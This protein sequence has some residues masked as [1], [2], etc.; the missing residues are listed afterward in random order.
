MSFFSYHLWDKWRGSGDN[1]LVQIKNKFMF[2]MLLSRTFTLTTLQRCYNS[3][4]FCLFSQ[5]EADRS[6]DTSSPAN[7]VFCYSPPSASAGR[8]H[9]RWRN[10]IKHAAQTNLGC[11]RKRMKCTK[12]QNQMNPWLLL[13]L[14]ST[15][16]PKSR[17]KQQDI[18]TDCFKEVI[19]LVPVPKRPK[20]TNQK[21]ILTQGIS[22]W[23]KT[24][25]RNQQVY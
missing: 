21:L 9:R 7:L 13:S 23:G 6:R 11:G 16:H 2:H 5:P 12:Q 17:T 8:L 10:N 4:S 3:S 22:C 24:L 1:F 18:S 25:R 14:Y 19:I 20:T 15:T